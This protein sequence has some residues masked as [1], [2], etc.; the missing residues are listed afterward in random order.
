MD[1]IPGIGPVLAEKLK[2]LLKNR[3]IWKCYKE[4]AIYELL[5]EFTKLFFKYKPMTKIPRTLLSAFVKKL[6]KHGATIAGSYRRGRDYCND[7]DI[8]IR[9]GEE[10]NI[11]EYFVKPVVCGPEIIRTFCKIKNIYVLCDIFL[12]TDLPPYLLYATGSKNFNLIMRS[13]AKK[14]GYLLNQNGLF[15]DDVKIPLNSEE[16]IFDKIGMQYVAPNMR[17]N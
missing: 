6:E 14:K 4:P 9:K 7:L 3:D 12:Y 13:V 16:E 17:N 10:A 11:L 8:L 15:K 5:P 1:D 2:P